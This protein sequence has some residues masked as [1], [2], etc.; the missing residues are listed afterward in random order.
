MTEAKTAHAG[1]AA[2]SRDQVAINAIR[3]LAVDMVEAAR[4]GHPGAPLGQ[5]P[6][7]YWLW[8]RYLRHDPRDPAWPNRD[9]FVLS[10]G[11]ASALIY[12]LL[13]LAGYDLPLEELK[14]FRQL[15]S[16]TPGHPEHGHTPG[17]ETTT[18]PLGQGIANAVGMAM[19]ERMLAAHFN[20]P[21]HRIIDHRTWVLA[22]DGDLME[23]VASEAC[24]LAG[25]LRLG[26]LNVFYDANQI[27]IDGS[28]DLT[29]TEDVAARYRAYGWH[30][31]AV[32]DGNDLEQLD[33]A[34]RRAH[35][36]VDRPTL[37]LVRTHIGYGS[38]RQDTAKVHGE[39]LGPEDAARTKENLGWPVEPPF[40]VPDEARQAFAEALARGG[41]A[42]AGWRAALE[43][44]RD[45]HPSLAAELE[46]RLAGRLPA[47]WEEKLPRFAPADGPLATRAASGKVLNAIAPALPE[48]IGGS[49]DLAG[50]NKTMIAG[51]GDFQPG[52]YGGRNLYFG[53]REHAMGAVMNGMALSRMLR[54]YGGTF[55]I[56][57]DYMR[58]AIRLAALMGLPVIYV[59]THDSIFLGED[60]PTHQPI[61]QLLALRAIPNLTLFRPADANETA[62]AWR[63]ALENRDGPT[64]LALSRQKLPVLEATADLARDGVARGA[65]V[66]A[67]GDGEPQALLLASGS[68]VALA[69]DAHAELARQGIRTRVVSMPCW[70]RFDAQEASYRESVL[71]AGVSKRLAIEAGVGLGWHKYVGDGGAILSQET[72]GVSAPGADV[73]RHFGFTAADVTRRVLELV[74]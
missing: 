62:E 34:M 38:P 8:T 33:A 28:T 57:S 56:F 35:D 52:N 24:S 32:G 68:E 18:G 26:R 69:L 63:Q 50:S 25:H 67:G 9:R 64:A 49:A 71:P 36:E 41:E 15:G 73:A 46:A 47:G 29:F 30:T 40:Y 11:H 2:G 13:H 4:S 45:A 44:Y 51:A 21:G 42:S 7:A 48:L 66:I 55:L 59:L 27:S 5:A 10:C 43:R 1:T 70:R 23:G 54:P 74:G 37:V 65:Y 61:S 12:A 14:R 6:L 31:L 20:R 53:V 58:P 60:G 17:V 72:F 16:K 19:A 3:F 22:S 39:P